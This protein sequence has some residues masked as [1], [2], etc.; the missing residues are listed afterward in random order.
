MV[1]VSNRS[2]GLINV[3]ITSTSGGDNRPFPIAA[4]GPEGWAINHW[5]RTG[6]ETVTV[7]FDNGATA[8]FAVDGSDHVNVYDGAYEK[9]ASLVVYVA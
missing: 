8:T 9:F 1:W 2:S 6:G 5:Q 7:K 3:S 4:R